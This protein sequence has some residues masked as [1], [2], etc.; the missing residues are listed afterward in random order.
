[1]AQ[2]NAAV[3]R[4]LVEGLGHH[5]WEMIE[6]KP[7]TFFTELSRD[8]MRAMIRNQVIV[9]SGTLNASPARSRRRS[10]HLAGG[11]TVGEGDAAAM[12]GV[13]DTETDS[14]DLDSGSDTSELQND[15]SANVQ[16]KPAVAAEAEKASEEEKQE[17][18]TS[19]G[20]SL[21]DMLYKPMMNVSINQTLSVS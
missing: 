11:L 10:S 4:A 6:K 15:D 8:Q 1:M 18:T 14:D 19:T 20:D 13:S 9:Q 16:E 2:K 5:F 21:G 12:D 3:Q 7:D 17:E